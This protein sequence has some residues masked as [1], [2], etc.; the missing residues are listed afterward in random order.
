[1]CGAPSLPSYFS[2]FPA[3]A[4]TNTQQHQQVR[5]NF[6]NELLHEGRA[7]LQ[8]YL[9]AS[10]LGRKVLTMPFHR[11]IQVDEAALGAMQAALTY[12]QQV[13]RLSRHS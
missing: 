3:A 10:V 6:L 8:Q 12:C 9:T 7:H 13:R 2:F 1:M 5:V 11:G 4:I